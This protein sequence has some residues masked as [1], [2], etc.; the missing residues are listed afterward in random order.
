MCRILCYNSLV[1]NLNPKIQAKR[2][3]IISDTTNGITTLKKNVIVDQSKFLKLK[4]KWIVLWKKM[5]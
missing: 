3:L 1:L 2:G 5:K 4:R